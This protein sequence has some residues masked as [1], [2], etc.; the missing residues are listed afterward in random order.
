MRKRPLGRLMIDRIAAVTSAK[1]NS[2]HPGA[3]S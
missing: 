1:R 2:I 3:A